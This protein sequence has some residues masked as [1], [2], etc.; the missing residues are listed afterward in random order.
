MEP[1]RRENS[2]GKECMFTL[3]LHLV[4]DGFRQRYYQVYIFVYN[5]LSEVS[6]HHRMPAETNGE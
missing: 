3:T 1:G 5:I 6:L 4:K 2:V